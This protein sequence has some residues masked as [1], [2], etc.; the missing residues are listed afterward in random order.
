LSR[1]RFPWKLTSLNNTER[2]PVVVICGPSGSGK[3]S[4]V[5]ATRGPAHKYIEEPSE[6]P[7]LLRVLSDL[8]SSA[9]DSQKWFL[10]EILHFVKSSDP[11]I[12]LLLDQDPSAIVNVYARWFYEQGRISGTMMTQLEAKLEEIEYI[13]RERWLSPRFVILLSANPQLLRNRV[14]TRD[15]SA[16]RLSW[17]QDLLARFHDFHGRHSASLTFDTSSTD[18]NTIASRAQVLLESTE[19]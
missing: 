14:L 5:N 2:R 12:P 9:A 18:V 10:E 15:G 11:A 13:L 17:F 7:H 8:N 16:P 3:T 6:N 19:S 1:R 4:V